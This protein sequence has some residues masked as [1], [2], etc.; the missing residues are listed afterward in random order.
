MKKSGKTHDAIFLKH[1]K[2]LHHGFCLFFSKI[3]SSHGW[4]Q[5]HLKPDIQ[6]FVLST[7]TFLRDI[8]GLTYLKNNFEFLVNH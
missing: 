7:E 6:R 1:F 3:K 5:S 4:G 8:C 2:R